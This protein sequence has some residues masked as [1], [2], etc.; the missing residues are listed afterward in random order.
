[1]ILSLTKRDSTLY[2]VE[3][4]KGCSGV[5]FFGIV[6]FMEWE[7]ASSAES[8][9]ARKEMEARQAQ[10]EARIAV[11]EHLALTSDIEGT[12]DDKVYQWGVENAELFG[13]LWADP[14][15]QGFVMDHWQDQDTHWLRRVVDIWA[16]FV[17]QQRAA[18]E[19]AKNAQREE[20]EKRRQKTDRPNS[21]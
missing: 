7:T 2:K 10:L 20:A 3:S 13:M 11:Q 5:H 14:Q 4:C 19:A 15:F 6:Q 21:W 8:D 12:P 9:E 17:K 18:Q 1:M 16:R